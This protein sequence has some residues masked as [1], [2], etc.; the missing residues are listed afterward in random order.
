MSRVD[1]PVVGESFRGVE[2]HSGFLLRQAWRAFHNAMEAALRAQGLTAPQYGVL[3]VL[4][5]R[6]GA[7]AADL[8]RASN[9]TAQAMTGLLAALEREGLIERHPHPF[10][11][12]ILQVE[13]TSEG[14]RRLDAAH[15]AVRRL[16]SAIEEGFTADEVAAA[17]AW[18][19]TAAQRL[20]PSTVPRTRSDG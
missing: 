15:P 8:A 6:P 5:R 12:R 11:G 10:H 20:Q 4:A 9:T 3:S 16:E 13:L 17:K 1:V 14:K 19:V 18:L 7:S 2:G